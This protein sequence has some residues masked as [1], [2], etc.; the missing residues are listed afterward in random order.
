MP[1]NGEA[2]IHILD[3]AVIV[4]ISRMERGPSYMNSEPSCLES[5]FKT[6]VKHQYI[7]KQLSS[8][9]HRRG[10][11]IHITASALN[12]LRIMT[13]ETIFYQHRIEFYT[14]DFRSRINSLSST[15]LF[16]K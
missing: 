4:Q 5:N 7:G 9:G 12:I 3:E 13:W 1:A 8:L 2:L 14:S 15:L 6:A 10:A 16:M 11:K